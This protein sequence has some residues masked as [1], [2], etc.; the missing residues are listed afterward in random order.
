MIFNDV[1]ECSKK[2]R[3]SN[4]RQGSPIGNSSHTGSLVP[5]GKPGDK[6][7]IE[8][9][10]VNMMKSAQKSKG[11]N[12][13]TET[14]NEDLPESLFKEGTGGERKTPSSMMNDK[15]PEISCGKVIVNDD[16]EY[17]E[18]SRTSNQRQ[19]SPLSL[20]HI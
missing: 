16:H 9:S 12:D 4:Q 19:G 15:C 6:K 2:S 3:T 10:D 13:K 18:K 8:I 7:G 17:S 11:R 14:T 20:I 5:E 1:H